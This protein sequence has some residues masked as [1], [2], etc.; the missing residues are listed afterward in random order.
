VQGKR[1]DS[2]SGCRSS[3]K[4]ENLISLHRRR[5]GT[6]AAAGD[7]RAQPARSPLR[8]RRPLRDEF[9]SVEGLEALA[10]ALAAHLAPTRP[11]RRGSRRFFARL[12]DNARALRHAYRT[13]GSDVRSAETVLS[14]A[15]WLLD[16]FHVLEAEFQQI[17]ISLPQSYYLELPSVVSPDLGE[18]PRVHAMAVE[19]V[20]QS[21]SRLDLQRLARFVSA[22]QTVA[23]LTIGELWAW[24]T[25]LKVALIEN[26]TGLAEE[27]LVVR[28]GRID[29]DRNL[30][31]LEAGLEGSPPPDLPDRVATATMVRLLERLREFGPRASQLRDQLSEKLGVR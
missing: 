20:R 4:K 17:R 23:P 26:V 19:L 11:S 28:A 25:M 29:A 1:R 16:N 21:G 10:K 18:T 2:P 8:D 5:D 6:K 3:L 30:A 13:F 12:E 7:A 27:I 9:L 14:A 24:P 31:S 15:E 22:Y